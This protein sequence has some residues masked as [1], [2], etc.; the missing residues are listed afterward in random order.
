MMKKVI[1]ALIFL[2]INIS[3]YSQDTIHKVNEIG[4]GF[5]STSSFSLRYQWGIDQMVYRISLVSLGG[6][7]SNAN[8]SYAQT[9]TIVSNN[10][11]YITL[12]STSNTP[13]NLTGG[14]NLSM[15]R[16]KQVNDKFGFMY[17]LA[18]GINLSYVE[19]KAET[20]YLYNPSNYNPIPSNYTTTSITS[21]Y[22]PFIGFVIGA[23]YKISKSFFVYA[24]ITP[25]VNFTYAQAKVNNTPGVNTPQNSNKITRTYGLS[26]LTNSGAMITIIYRIKG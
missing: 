8:T 1:I 13:I 24:E 21:S 4:I 12:G 18:I 9:N 15:V 5:A 26:G 11:D 16:I 7:N 6:T 22:A 23:R 20:N 25:N 2:A 17:G 10:Y 19:T 14:L 3:V